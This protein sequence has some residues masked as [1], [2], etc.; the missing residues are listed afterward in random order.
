MLD[1][2]PLLRSALFALAPE[3]SHDLTL[4]ALAL[5]GDWHL[6]LPWTAPAGNKV[7]LMGI[8]FPNRVGLA[9]GLDKNGVAIGALARMGFGFIEVGTL[10]PRPQPG[11]P[12]PRMFRLTADDA[13]IN[14]MGF[15]NQGVDA[16]VARLRARPF[17]GVLGIN[18]GK[19]KDTPVERA[20]EDYSYCLGRVFAYASYI[21][22]NLSS[23]NTPGLRDLQLGESL[24]R[25]LVELARHRAELT[26]QQGRSVP[27]LVKIAP[28]LAAEDVEAIVD[29]LIAHE[30]DGLIATNTTVQRPQLK[31]GAAA[32]EA[33]G[34]SGKPLADLADRTL[35]LA[36]R[37][38]GGRLV[39]IGVG[40]VDSVARAHRKRELGADLVQL[41]TGLIY[42]GPGLVAEVVRGLD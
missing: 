10:T 6:P 4:R 39:V 26:R 3:Q 24:R 42:R 16:L 31:A 2:Y 1:P 19:N 35:A 30:I 22:I 37:R 15:N 8:D 21:V 33:G 28:D 25:L 34:L 41:Y 11:N 7:R 40:G 27:M 5:A 14:R 23:P 9:A 38:A 32:Q 29:D 18:I 12:R 17:D 20:V 13:L 36:A